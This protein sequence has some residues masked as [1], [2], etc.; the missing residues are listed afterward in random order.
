MNE[1]RRRLSDERPA[2]THRFRIVNHVG[3]LTVGL[4]DDGSP[5]ELFIR[6]AK[7]GSELK[8][9]LDAWAAAV[10]IG[11]Q[12]GAP[13][14]VFLDKF[15]GWAFEPRGVTDNQEIPIAQ[16]VID[17]VARWMRAKFHT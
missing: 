9:T 10:S 6:I 2:I 4:Y 15:T 1:A 14:E 8:G 12:Y 5:G 17:Y 16:S 7:E 13:L 11:L 3:Y